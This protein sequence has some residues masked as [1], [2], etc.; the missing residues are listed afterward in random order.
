[1][2][3]CRMN[4]GAPTVLTYFL[5]CSSLV[6]EPVVCFL[7]RFLPKLGGASGAAFFWVALVEWLAAWARGGDRPSGRTPAT[8]DCR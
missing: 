8:A 7:G 1:M 3:R 5:R 2:L 6:P 4:L